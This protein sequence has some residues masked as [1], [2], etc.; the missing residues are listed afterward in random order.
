MIHLTFCSSTYKNKYVLQQGLERGFFKVDGINLSGPIETS[1]D[2]SKIRDMPIINSGIR[3]FY[4]KV[5]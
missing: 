4:W 5:A 2:H 1:L 3:V